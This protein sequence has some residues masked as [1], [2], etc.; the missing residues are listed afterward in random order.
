M[1]IVRRASFHIVFVLVVLASLVLGSCASTKLASKNETVQK[2]PLKGRDKVAFD[3]TFFNGMSAKYSGDYK[4]ASAYFQQCLLVDPNNAAVKFELSNL[5]IQMGYNEQAVVMGEEVVASE[6][7]NRWFLE[8]LAE[9]YLN[10]KKYKEGAVVYEKLIQKNPNERS[11]Y[12]ELGSAYLYDNDAPNAIRIY[13]NLEAL[14]GFENSLAEQLY[15]LYEHQGMAIKAESKLVELMDSNPS[16]IRYVSMLAAFYKKRGETEK[17]I[18]LYETLKTEHPNDPYV[19]LALYEYYTELGQKEEAFKNLEEAFGS[20]KVKIDSK[21]G[22]LLALLD[23]SVK[24]M[25]VK[26]EMYKLMEVLAEAHP[27]DPK[28]WAVYG[29][30]LYEENKKKDAR[31]K[32]LK[33]IAIDNSKY[34]VWNQVLFIDSELNE[35]DSILVHSAS[36]IELFPN[37]VL[38]HYFNGL[39]HLQKKQYLPA[40]TSLEEAKE[41]S[42]GM[43]ELEVQIMANLGDAYYQSGNIQKAWLAYDHSLRM[44]PSNDYV[45]N[46]YAYFLSLE[47]VDMQKAEEMSKRT[48][49]RNPK[50]PVYLDTYGWVL[51]KSAKYSEAVVYLQKAVDFDPNKSAE[52]REHLGDAQAMNGQVRDALENW[53]LALIKGGG[54]N[55]LAEKIKLKK[56]IP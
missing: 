45:L 25:E 55:K 19:K 10:A 8:N 48:V 33:S 7:D 44:N 15:K 6:P 50:S 17:S 54:S 18:N 22:I 9:V 53:K 31:E 37:Q 41:L 47:G 2:T 11:Y 42:Y 1:I 38:P 12:Y 52:I 28:T 56:Y 30:F 34:K 23:V 35:V 36:C 14:T 32:Y 26:A 16:E 39:G 40:I 29:D 24:D 13:E 43:P 51:F 3:E 20:K 27:S 49:D 21:M 46:N 4:A 5:F